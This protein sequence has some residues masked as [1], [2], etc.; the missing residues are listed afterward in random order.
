MKDMHICMLY[1]KA[2]EE[3]VMYSYVFLLYQKKTIELA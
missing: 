3:H 1:T 2:H